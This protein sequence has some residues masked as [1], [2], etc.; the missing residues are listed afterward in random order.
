[1]SETPNQQVEC[2]SIVQLFVEPLKLPEYHLSYNL[3]IICDASGE[4]RK[5]KDSEEISRFRFVSLV[6]VLKVQVPVIACESHAAPQAQ[7]VLAVRCHKGRAR[8]KRSRSQQSS[9][10]G[11]T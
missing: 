7:L 8:Q 4:R 2:P 5:G 6:A 3:V 1:M 11:D 10:A 9:V